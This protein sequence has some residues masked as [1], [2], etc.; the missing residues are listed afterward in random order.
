[1]RE[2][3]GAEEVGY[4]AGAFWLW[5]RG[6]GLVFLEDGAVEE[7][8][9]AAGDGRD[10]V[11]GDEDSGKVQWIGGGD[12]DSGFGG[13]RGLQ[14]AG[15]AERVD[16]FGEGVLLAE[17][18]GDETATADLATGFETTE[19][20]EEVAPFG[21]VGFAGEELA[22]EDS[23]AAEEDASVG[24]ECGVGA[25]GGGDGGLC[26]GLNILRSPRLRSETWGTRVL[27]GRRE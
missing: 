18:A 8:D 12:G 26:C 14:R 1:M 16:G 4:A 10:A 6:D 22:E 2:G 25:A 17:G 27:R 3:L 13:A 11:A 15:F 7:D 19:D 5:C 24:V 20:G 23:V 9:F 21:G